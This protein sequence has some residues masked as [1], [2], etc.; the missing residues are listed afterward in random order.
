M[1][2]TAIV[3]NEI[4]LAATDV[5]EDL[6]KLLQKEL[7]FA[8][9]KLGELIRMGYSIWRVPKRIVCYRKLKTGYYLPIGFGARLRQYLTERGDELILNDQRSLK[10]IQPVPIAITLKPEQAAVLGQILKHYRCILEAR[11]GFGKTMMGIKILSERRQ[12]TLI[13][14]H[15]RALLQQWQKR[16]QDF[17]TLSE[18]DLGLI[19]EGKWQLGRKITLAMYQTLLSRGT[20]ELQAEF[21]LVI[22]DECHHVPANTFAKI[23]KSMAAKYCLGLTA[24][25]Y[26]KDK[27]DKLMNFYIGKIIP[28]GSNETSD[29]GSLLPPSKIKTT[30]YWRETDLLIPGFADKEFTE[31]GT[32]LAADRRR[33]RLVVNDVLRVAKQGAKIMVLSERVG[34][35]EKIF[36]LLGQSQPKL[37]M[38]L[39]TGQQKKV[40]RSELFSRLKQGEFQIMVATGGVVGEGFDWPMVDHLFLAFPFSWKGKLIQYVG[41]I[42][43]AYPGK[44][45]AFVYDYVDGQMSIFRAMQRKRS[46]GYR[47]LGAI[48]TP[49]PTNMI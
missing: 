5:D 7:T 3:S 15:T 35:A 23:V 45:A 19:G 12:K 42:Q 29:I 10:P 47:E 37:K 30:V 49:F 9:P 39:V 20:K 22:V 40:A 28:T 46:S 31:L 8:N 26:R 33:L 6:A 27:L 2:I 24:T 21:G 25:P 16:L 38:T 4:F 17:C 14:V 11:P 44:N 48:F 32:L 34:Q 13:I 1:K 43:R 41:R 36:A 18:G